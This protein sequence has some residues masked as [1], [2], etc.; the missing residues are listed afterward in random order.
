M[1]RQPSNSDDNTL[2]KHASPPKPRLAVRVGV[3][4]YDPN[5]LSDTS[6]SLV[7]QQLT[8]V[9]CAIEHAGHSILKD[10]PDVYAQEFSEFR[11]VSRIT[12]RRAQP[13]PSTVPVSWLIESVFTSTDVEK[14]R[15][16]Q[17][18]ENQ[19]DI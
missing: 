12:G 15:V 14:D 11:L 8:K 19:S 5:N 3:D 18:D 7:G 6:V 9:L 16:Q 2:F 17:N 4:G 1:C 13:V 10:E